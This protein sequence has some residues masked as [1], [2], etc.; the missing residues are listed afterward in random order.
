MRVEDEEVQVIFVGCTYIAGVKNCMQSSGVI[1]S[2]S[3][4]KY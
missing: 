4:H 1:G 3:Q 2:S